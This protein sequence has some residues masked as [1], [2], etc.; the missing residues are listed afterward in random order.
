LSL[1]GFFLANFTE[2][3]EWQTKDEVK[4]SAEIERRESELLKKKR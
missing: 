4:F 3:A 1:G 2:A